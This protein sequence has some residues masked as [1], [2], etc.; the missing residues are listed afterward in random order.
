MSLPPHPKH[1]SHLTLHLYRPLL[2]FEYGGVSSQQLVLLLMQH[3]I[4]LICF[5]ICPSHT[6]WFHPTHNCYIHLGNHGLANMLTNI[7]SNRF[8]D[9]LASTWCNGLIDELNNSWGRGLVNTLS[10][11]WHK[12]LYPWPRILHCP[13]WC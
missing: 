5:L 9:E 8:V 4:L 2:L 11:I 10:N 7:W 6:F 1:S 12:H 3:F 13:H